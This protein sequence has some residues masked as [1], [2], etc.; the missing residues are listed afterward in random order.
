MVARSVESRA[1][2]YLGWL[3]DEFEAFTAPPRYV[4]DHLKSFRSRE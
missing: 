3:F 2:S 4:P 1:A